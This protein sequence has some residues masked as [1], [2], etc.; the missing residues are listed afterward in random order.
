MKS[1]F[2]TSVLV[3]A[4]W[5]D[6][7]H[8][9]VSLDL[10]Y[11]ARKKEAACGP[12]PEK[13]VGTWRGKSQTGK[14]RRLNGSVCI[15]NAREKITAADTGYW[16]G[17]KRIAENIDRISMQNIEPVQ[18]ERQ[19]HKSGLNN[20]VPAFC[21]GVVYIQLRICGTAVAMRYHRGIQ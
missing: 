21:R 17:I 7:P 15:K 13:S 19:A 6:H 9:H 18:S 12:D 1:F 11:D 14:R 3:A 20:Q 2:D 10:F 4:F 5:E 16:R 8:H